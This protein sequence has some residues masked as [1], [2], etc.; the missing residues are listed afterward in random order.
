LAAIVGTDIQT[1]SAVRFKKLEGAMRSWSNGTHRQAPAAQPRNISP[2]EKSKDS[3][4]SWLTRSRASSGK[5]SDTASIHARAL[6]CVTAT[7]LG[8][9]VLP[10]VNKT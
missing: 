2:T 9:P 6:A 8:V 5:R 1:V 7:P 3:A 4:A 10:D